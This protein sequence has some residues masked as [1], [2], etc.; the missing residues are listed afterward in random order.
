MVPIFAHKTETMTTRPLARAVLQRKAA[1][2]ERT[3]SIP[4]LVH[5]VLRSPGRPLDAKTRALFE[6]RF[7]M[8]FSSVRL[9]TDQK[10]ARSALA[11]NALAYTVG[12]DIV[13][14]EGQ[15]RPSAAHGRELLAHELTHVVQQRTSADGPPVGIGSAHGKHESEAEAVSRQIMKSEDGPSTGR[16]EAQISGSPVIVS[17]LPKYDADCQL[18]EVI[19]LTGALNAANQMLDVAV[20]ELRPLASGSVKKGRVVDLLNVHFHDPSNVK[21]RARS[22]LKNYE[23]IKAYLK[24][25]NFKCHPAS[26]NCPETKDQVTEAFTLPVAGAQIGLC[27]VYWQL[28]CTEQGRVLIHEA[29]HHVPWGDEDY[30]YVHAD[31]YEALA[32][33]ER[34]RLTTVKYVRMQ[35]GKYESL[36]AAEAGEN[37][38]TYGQFAAMVFPGKPSCSL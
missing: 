26:V 36:T 2:V 19:Q 29:Y 31:D 6:P 9:H 17:R 14:G 37:A 33:E 35:R 22:V 21:G 5:E 10:A 11:V 13:F 34:K 7:G 15:Y 30:A 25:P 28:D 16:A 1:G 23:K 32:P 18:S 8:D 20:A 24:S 12:R 4:A 27:P 38:D 3:A